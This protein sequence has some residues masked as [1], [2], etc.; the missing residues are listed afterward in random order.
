[1]KASESGPR[2]HCKAGFSTISVVGCH[3]KTAGYAKGGCPI[4]RKPDLFEPW[5][6]VSILAVLLTLSLWCRFE[7]A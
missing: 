7:V 5:K 4:W 6:V 2:H 1:N 3:R